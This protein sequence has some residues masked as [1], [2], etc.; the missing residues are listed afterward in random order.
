MY[1]CT[2]DRVLRYTVHKCIAQ[3]YTY[4]YVQS[5]VYTP[6]VQYTPRQHQ[7]RTRVPRIFAG[8]GPREWCV[9]LS[10]MV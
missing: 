5:R 10:R 2:E 3:V 6:L 1:T 7:K 8:V 4:M 9:T